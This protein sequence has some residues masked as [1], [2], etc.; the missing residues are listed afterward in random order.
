M[1]FQ[2]APHVIPYQGSK[3]KLSAQIIDCF[4]ANIKCL[5]EPFAGSAAITLAAAANSKAE[6]FVIADKLT[7][8]AKLWEMIIFSPHELIEEYSVHWNEQLSDPSGY[9]LKVRSDYNRNQSPSLLLYLIA[10]CVKNS[11]RFN[12]NGEFNQ[13][14]D[15]RRLGLKPEKLMK[16]VHKVSKMLRGRTKIFSAD[17]REVLTTATS[18]DLIY[19]D[20]PWQGTSGKKDPRY[21]FLLDINE[22]ITELDSL[23]SRNVPFIL[24]FDGSCGDR[25]Y[26]KGLPDDLQLKKISI[27]AGRSTQATLLGRNEETVESLYLSKTLAA[28]MNIRKSSVASG[29][30]SAQFSFSI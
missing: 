4:P 17:F 11:I 15:K 6:S 30:P 21:A 19:M 12:R 8:L 5:Y 14:A 7:P 22:L 25:T 13:G 18:N 26:G 3:R 23:N 29:V 9:Y 10:R 27:N 2:L 28:R 16:E 24:S 1:M 20:P